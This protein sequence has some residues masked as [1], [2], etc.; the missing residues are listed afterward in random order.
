MRPMS[1]TSPSFQGLCVCEH[2]EKF[3]LAGIPRTVVRLPYAPHPI[4]S[5]DG[6]AKPYFTRTHSFSPLEHGEQERVQCRFDSDFPVFGCYDDFTENRLFW[7]RYG[8]VLAVRCTLSK[9]R[10]VED[11]YPFWA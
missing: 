8:A 1:R 2:L 5:L 3:V 9:S 7:K 10:K 11:S 6:P 4:L